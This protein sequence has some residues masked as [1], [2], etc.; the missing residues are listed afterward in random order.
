LKRLNSKTSNGKSSAFFLY[1]ISVQKI[2]GTEL[3]SLLENSIESTSC[4]IAELLD[5][6]PSSKEDS[7][8]SNLRK[9]DLKN[10]NVDD[11]I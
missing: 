8:S 1:P 5:E 6:S 11:F 3:L 7:S 4:K 10:F 2:Q 9:I